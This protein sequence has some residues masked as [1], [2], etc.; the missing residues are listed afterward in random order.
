[1][2]ELNHIYL[3]HPSLSEWDYKEEG[4]QWLDCH[5]EGRC[6]YAILR[7]SKNEKLA[8]V[9]NFSAQVQKDYEVKIENAN[10]GDILLYS[11]WN[12]FGGQTPEGVEKVQFDNG[13]LRCNLNPFSAMIFSVK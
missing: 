2:K 5:Q 6:I 10:S 1:M 4:F 11:D 3:K 9:F 13:T 12:R 7:Q 8:A